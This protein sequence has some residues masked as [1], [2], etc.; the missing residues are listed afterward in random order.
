MTPDEILSYVS[1]VGGGLCG[2]PEILKSAVGLGLNLNLVIFGVM[3][4][5]YAILGGLN[6]KFEKDVEDTIKDMEG[7]DR[8]GTRT[9]TQL[10][11]PLFGSEH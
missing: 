10:R 6:F 5:S 2:Y 7:A 4:V 3:C 11:L 9:G 8:S 1:N